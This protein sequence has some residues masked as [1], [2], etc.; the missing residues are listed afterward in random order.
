MTIKIKKSRAKVKKISDVVLQ[1]PDLYKTTLCGKI[2]NIRYNVENKEMELEVNL[3]IPEARAYD[4]NLFLIRLW[5]LHSEKEAFSLLRKF[6]KAARQS[7]LVIATGRYWPNNKNIP[8]LLNP[9]ITLVDFLRP[10]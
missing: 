3:N 2:G 8:I 6:F 7:T 10:D 4:N 5:Y 1:H 9:D